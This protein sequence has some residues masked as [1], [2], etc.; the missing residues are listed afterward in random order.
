[1]GLVLQVQLVNKLNFTGNGQYLELG[2]DLSEMFL[3]IFIN[4]VILCLKKL[5]IRHQ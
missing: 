4:N 1:M 2:G 3:F 5:V